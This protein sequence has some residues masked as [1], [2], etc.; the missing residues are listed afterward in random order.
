MEHEEATVAH[1]LQHILDAI[2]EG[3]IVIDD[4]GSVERINPEACR[5]LGFSS[6]AAR[7]RRL[8]DLLGEEHPI[9]SSAQ[10]A[11]ETRRTSVVDELPLRRPLSEE[12]L[13]DLTSCPLLEEHGTP[14]GVVL[15]LRDRTIHAALQEIVN[16]RERLAT[17]GDIASGI[18][19]EVKNPLGGIRG[20]AE[21]LAIRSK[22][23]KVSETANLIVREV[24]R[25]AD[26]VEELMVFGRGDQL[27]LEPVNVHR[28]LD[29]VLELLAHDPL[30][31]KV[32]M[33]RLYDPSIPEIPADRNRL[34]QVFLNLAHNA[35]QAMGAE[36]GML[37]VST[38]VTLDHRLT[39]RN[40]ESCPTVV[41]KFVDSG[42]GIP[43]DAQE[44]LLT[45]FFTTR[46]EGTGLGLPVAVHWISLHG[47]TLRLDNNPDRG[48]TA[49]IALPLRRNH[50]S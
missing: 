4:C 13:I 38:R 30:G 6:D 2:A 23:P 12:A 14:T 35:L 33:R 45:P 17:F 40:G 37:E 43:E 41:I 20:A 18:A 49:R 8:P 36:G 15:V 24:D 9:W 16:E 25:I 31:E 32:V 1:D 5:L 44:H 10:S 3:V 21:L 27:Q 46:T 7:G 19:H 50:E 28:V 34:T 29:E 39:S 22:E 48:A 26:L 47:G 42:P 11:L